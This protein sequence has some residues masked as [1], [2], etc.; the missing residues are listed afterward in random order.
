MAGRER[1]GARAALSRLPRWVTVLGIVLVLVVLTGI[2]ALLV[3]GISGLEVRL[4]LTRTVTVVLKVDGEPAQTLQGGIACNMHGTGPCPT[5]ADTGTVT[6]TTPTGGAT[7]Q[8]TALPS[9]RKIQVPVGGVV[10][11]DAS[12]DVDALFCLILLDGKVLGQGS[13]PNDGNRTTCRAAIPS[14]RFHG[15]P[16]TG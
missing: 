12:S 1:L 7:Y 13:S 3:I 5:P 11:L 14:G 2:A 4:G 6:Y 15:L 9:T 10:T 8:Y 16:G